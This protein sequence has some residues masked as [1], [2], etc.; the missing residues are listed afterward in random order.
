MTEEEADSRFFVKLET[1]SDEV[2]GEKSV[3]LI[4]LS[5]LATKLGVSSEQA[6]ALY[7]NY[8]RLRER[9]FNFEKDWKRKIADRDWGIRISRI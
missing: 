6:I 4:Q 9:R 1:Y 3:H 5:D 8:R 2:L 7:E